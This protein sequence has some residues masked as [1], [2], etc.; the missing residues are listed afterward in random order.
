MKTIKWASA[1]I[2]ALFTVGTGI[3]LYA[4]PGDEVYAVPG[5]QVAIT[6]AQASI[7]G[8]F[9]ID[10]G[11]WDGSA[12]ALAKLCV[13][14]KSGPSF[15]ALVCVKD[16]VQPEDV[17]IGAVRTGREKPDGSVEYRKCMNWRNITV[18][19]FTAA[20]Q[21]FIN[22]GAWAGDKAD[23]SLGCVTRE[24]NDTGPD[25]FFAITA[26][27]IALDPNGDVPPGARKIGVV[28]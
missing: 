8:S 13:K 16:Y 17:P 24:D 25:D 23:L 21:Y 3:Y 7:A 18:A 26:G 20:G 11:W 15:R 2:A 1:V 22:V 6:P 27:V 5:G 19:Q 4:A 10:N 9:A 14:R 12:S 28:D